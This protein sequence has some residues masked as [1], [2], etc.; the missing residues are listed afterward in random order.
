MRMLIALSLFL[1]FVSQGMASTLSDAPSGLMC[2]L[3]RAPDRAVITDHQPEFGWIMNDTERGAKQTAFHILVSSSLKNIEN[4][5]GDMWDSGKMTSSQSINVEYQGKGLSTLSEYW[6]KVKTWSNS[7]NQ[8]SWS[9]PQKFRTGNFSDKNRKWPGESKWIKTNEGDW[10]LENRQRADYIEKKPIELLNIGQGHYF[11]DFGKAAFATLKIKLTSPKSGDSTVVYLGER[12]T[13]ENVVHKNPGYSNIGFERSTIQLKKGTH[14][15]LIELP[16][17]RSH[18]PNSQVLAEHMPEVAPYR[19]AEI[20]NS[21][22]KISKTDIKQLALYYYFDDNAAHFNSSSDNLNHVWDLCKYTL[23]A[24]PF[25]A[26]YADGNRERMPYE[27]DAFVQ[28]LG[29]YSVDREYS[30]GRYT[31]QFLL[32]NPAWPTEWHLHSVIMAWYDY[33]YT[34][35]AESIKLYYNEFA[36]KT[37]VAL[38]GPNGLISTKTG[39]ATKEYLADLHFHG[40]NFRDIVDWPPGT[41]KGKK[42]ARNASPLPGGERDGYVFTTYNTVVNALHYRTLVIL[43]EFANVLDKTEEAEFY[44]NQASLVKKSFNEV[45]LVKERGFYRDGD[46][47]DHASLH[48]N[49]FPLA[50]GLVPKEYVS[51]VAEHIKSRGLACGVYGAQYLLDALYNAGE[52]E[53]ALKLMTSEEKRSWINMLKVGSTMTTEAWDEYYKPNLTWNHAWGAA[54]GNIIPRRMFGIQ[55]LKP[56]WEVAAVRPQ[57]AQLEKTE[58]KVP[59]IRGAIIASW[60]KTGIE[61]TFTLQIPANMDAKVW[62]PGNSVLVD[63]ERIQKNINVNVIEIGEDRVICEIASG[64]YR[65][66]GQLKQ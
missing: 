3:L 56:G 52:D 34:G 28:Q 32:F 40:K 38:A 44:K 31:N 61:Y 19:F 6:W 64:K 62:L 49:M 2:E 50:V 9:Q 22:S 55:P 25:L 63:G 11:A 46:E 54:P 37:H 48:A 10:V 12:K 41:P 30:V 29:H 18:Y 33:L 14:E 1:L 20:V 15:Y 58:I 45:F 36:K 21:P 16:R 35:N 26:L 59:T 4:N 7:K 47:T 39:L 57:L 13:D 23:K 43:S 42:Q 66:S 65:F 51:T 53:Y 24:T 27:A 17:H 60:Q 5:V 8:S